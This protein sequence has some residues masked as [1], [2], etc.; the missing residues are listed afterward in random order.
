M[1]FITPAIALVALL[2]AALAV[3]I[4]MEKKITAGKI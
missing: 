4:R 1:F 2:L 3:L